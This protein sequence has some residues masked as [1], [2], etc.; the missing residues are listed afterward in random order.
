MPNGDGYALIKEIRSLEYGEARRIPAIAYTTYTRAEDRTRCLAKGYQMHIAKPADP[1][2]LAAA[3]SSLAA[4][5]RSD[6]PS[7]A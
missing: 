1:G 2:E 5:A 7:G 6:K 3:I 4:A